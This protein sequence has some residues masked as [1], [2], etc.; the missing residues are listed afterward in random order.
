MTPGIDNFRR[1]LLGDLDNRAQIAAERAA[2]EQLHPYAKHVTREITDRIRNLPDEAGGIYVL[3]ESYYQYP[4]QEMTTKPLLFFIEPHGADSVLLS[5]LVVPERLDAWAV[6]NDNS[7]L[8]F[9]YAE[10]RPN[11][12]FGKALYAWHPEAGH[13]TVNHPCEL[14]DGKRFSLIETLTP[15]ALHVMELLER[16]GQRLTPYATPL[17]YRRITDA[18]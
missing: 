14:G 18:D 8:Y 4:G 9:D 1:I 16:D 3:E 17:I 7:E 10:L 6:R 12:W 15:E 5:S 13:F 11:P 2:G